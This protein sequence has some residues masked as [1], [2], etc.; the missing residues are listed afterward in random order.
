MT[1]VSEIL[2][3]K[4]D[5]ANQEELEPCLKLLW[6]R[7]SSDFWTFRR[8]INGRGF[9]LGWFPEELAR[10]FQKFYE[11]YKEGLAP[12]LILT[13]PPQHG[14]SVAVIDFLAWIMGK[15]PEKAH[16][17][18]SFSDRLGT[19][20]NKAIKRIM[21]TAAYREIFPGVRLPSGQGVERNMANNDSLFELPGHRGGFRNT[22]IGGAITGE[23][24]TGIGIIDDFIKGREQAESATQRDKVSDW[25]SDDFGT[26]FDERAAKIILAT[27]WHV[28]DLIGRLLSAD[29]DAEIQLVEFP[30][31]ATQDEKHRKT[32]AALFPEFKSL[33]FLQKR[34]KAMAKYS[35]N[36]LY[37]CKPTIQGGNLLKHD[38]LKFTN[39]LPKPERIFLTADT[40][41]KIK[42]SND[43]SVIQAW[44]Y[45]D[46]KIY[47]YDMIRDKMEAPQLL[48]AARDFYTKHLAIAKHN[49][50]PLTWFYIEDAS[51]GIG[52]IQTLR[53]ESVRVKGITRSKDKVQRANDISPYI[54]NGQVWILGS[55]P[56]V[57]AFE[58]EYVQFPA[59]KNDD[60][61]D[62]LMDACEQTFTYEPD[63]FIGR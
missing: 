3:L 47:L 61:I 13:T 39:K 45:R 41:S 1:L 29:T 32:G 52:L 34:R 50:V 10:E 8:V 15:D 58:T 51:S 44:A 35:W 6:Q 27:R 19:R 28:D 38:W 7:S 12:T 5:P 49:S 9:T 55:C 56:N 14:K 31:I 24:I 48:R 42:E 40:A 37:Q 26:R 23:T 60:T 54:E 17:F 30:A 20:A 4:R 63:W 22:T 62:P 46:D 16:I 33:A 11:Q 59:G 25:Y 57:S 2:G 18:A 43:Y 21:Q 36:S 53:G